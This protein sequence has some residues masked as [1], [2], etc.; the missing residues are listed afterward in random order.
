M[1]LCSPYEMQEILLGLLEFMIA[2]SHD[3]QAQ[4]VFHFTTTVTN[5][6]LIVRLQ[7]NVL[8]THPELF[9]NQFQATELQERNLYQS[10]HLILIQMIIQHH[11][12]GKIIPSLINDYLEYTIRI[13]LDQ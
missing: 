1:C 12:A 8:T 2:L 11:Y 3:K 10:I 7:S 9:L 13:P 4:T 6:E 5:T